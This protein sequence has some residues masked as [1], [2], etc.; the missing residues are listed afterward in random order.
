MCQEKV[1]SIWK[2]KKNSKSKCGVNDSTKI[3]HEMEI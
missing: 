1:K 3:Q 2:K